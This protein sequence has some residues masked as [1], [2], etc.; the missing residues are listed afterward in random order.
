MEFVLLSSLSPGG[1]TLGGVNANAIVDW[2]KDLPAVVKIG[3]V[4]ADRMAA[5]LVDRFRKVSRRMVLLEG[6]QGVVL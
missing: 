2:G 1:G 3:A 4:I 5:V 6:G